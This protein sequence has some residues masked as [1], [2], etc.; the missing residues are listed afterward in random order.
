MEGVLPRPV[1]WFEHHL[2][3]EM[4]GGIAKKSAVNVEPLDPADWHCGLVSE[5]HTSYR[6]RACGL[7]CR[8]EERQAGEQQVLG[9][10]LATVRRTEK[11]E[12]SRRVDD[13]DIRSASVKVAGDDLLDDHPDP[14]GHENGAEPPHA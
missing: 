1:T 8:A 9:G 11:V 12:I 14:T 7:R 13:D 10:G 4:P 5:E 3:I 2:S 6:T